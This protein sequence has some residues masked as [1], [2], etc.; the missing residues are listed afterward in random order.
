MCAGDNAGLFKFPMTH[1]CRLVS[2]CTVK[3][4]Q[5][6]VE[7]SNVPYVSAVIGGNTLPLTGQAVA[8]LRRRAILLSELSA[9]AGNPF[10][11]RMNSGAV[12]QPHGDSG[13]D[14]S[15]AQ[16]SFASAEQQQLLQ[17]QQQLPQAQQQ[18][19]NP[20]TL[21]SAPPA[22]GTRP[23]HNT[24]VQQQNQQHE[25]ATQELLV[26][27]LQHLLEV[28]AESLQLLDVDG[29]VRHF[30]VLHEQLNFKW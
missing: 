28:G 8:L 4:P 29:E 7:C 21:V 9:V 10:L 24:S 22:R 3:V 14:T 15:L 17:Q 16:L 18:P 23:P 1:S 27:A 19:G 5:E 2:I 13:P 11:Y 12:H 25:R 26:R 30:S 20:E 6:C